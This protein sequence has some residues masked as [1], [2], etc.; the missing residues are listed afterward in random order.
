MIRFA[1]IAA[2]LGTLT[3][4]VMNLSPAQAAEAKALDEA[5]V[6]VGTYTGGKSEG[7]Y[8]YRLDLESGRSTPLGLA[9]EVKNPSFVAVHPSGKFLYSVSEISDLDGKPTGGVS[10]FAI[11]R[12]S[13]KL[14][15]LNHQS[16]E[17]AGPCH[18]TVDKTGRVAMVANYGGGSVASLPIASDGKLSPA[19]SAIQ[20]EGKVFLPQRQGG[21]HAHSINPS[22]DNRFAV[23]ADL[24]L[25]KLF[26]YRLDP[27]AGTLAPND[28]PSASV[29]PGLGTAA[30]CVSTFGQ[31]CL[32]DQRNRLHGDGV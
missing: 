6:Y 32:R 14:T 20:H 30:F 21:P 2:L 23:A 11:D 22:P 17:G 9:A 19:A 18:V 31:A 29:P 16:S 24:G 26:V 27:A 15:K 4:T 8:A 13:G 28:P 25:D 1:V 3:G 10:A 12:S 5:L 7:I